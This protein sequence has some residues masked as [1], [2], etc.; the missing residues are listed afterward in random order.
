[1]CI[2]LEGSCFIDKPDLYLCDIRNEALNSEIGI[3]L[4]E[5][6]IFS[7]PGI[8]NKT[9]FDLDGVICLD[10][11]DEKNEN[12]YIEYIKSPKTITIP[13][14]DNIT[15]CT[16]RLVKYK[17]YTYNYLINIGLT[18]INLIMFNSDSYEERSK[19]PSYV[20]KSIVYDELKDYKLFV[21]SDDFQAQMIKKLTGKAV[22]CTTT[23]IMY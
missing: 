17:D 7:N 4:Y 1:M 5:W 20:Y 13:T 10:P 22:F 11:P 6:N 3:A 19:T 23:N 16:Y 2:Y 12:E 21:E 18:N 9:V 14:T 15:I 8:M